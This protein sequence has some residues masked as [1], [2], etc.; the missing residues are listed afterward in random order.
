MVVARL[1]IERG[2]E[3]GKGKERKK[4]RG[5]KEGKTKN[6]GKENN[7]SYDVVYDEESKRDE[8]AEIPES[9]G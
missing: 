1:A 8:R 9:V 7:P 4:R 5:G 2:E 3:R 6:A